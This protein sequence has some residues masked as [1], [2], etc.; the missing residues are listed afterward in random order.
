VVHISH[1]KDGSHHHIGLL[2]QNLHQHGIG[3]LQ[4]QVGLNISYFQ[5]KLSVPPPLP[6]FFEMTLLGLNM[7]QS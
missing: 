5:S 1:G 2:A 7:N 3:I 4:P 6:F